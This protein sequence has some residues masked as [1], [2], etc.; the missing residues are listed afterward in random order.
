MKVSFTC[1]SVVG[2][3]ALFMMA[4]G[5][6]SSPSEATSLRGI[7]S[8]PEG[9]QASPSKGG[10][11]AKQSIV[12]QYTN[13]CANKPAPT[14]PCDKIKKDAVEILTEDLRTL[15]S[16]ANRTYLPA[17][18]GIFKSRA[19]AL[20]LLVGINMLFGGVSLIAMALHARSVDPRT[21]PPQP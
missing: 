20:G 12:G 5:S 14:A 10:I 8:T 4:L 9:V 17:I 11:L 18:L 15:G 16:S 19:W 7:G 2:T 1:T 6:L 13:T 21:T 3:S